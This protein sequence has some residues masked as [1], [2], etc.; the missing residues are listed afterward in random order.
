MQIFIRNC[1]GELLPCEVSSTETVEM[2]KQRI[3]QLQGTEVSEIR[4]AS[5]GQDLFDEQLLGDCTVENGILE[6]LLRLRGAGKKRKK[7]NYTKPKKIKHKKKKVKLATL[8]Y[9]KVDGQNKVV[10]LRRQCEHPMCGPGIFMANHFD[11]Q[12]CG[13]CFLTYKVDPNAPKTAAK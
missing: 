9:Y 10:R 4:L 5:M 7:K 3:S 12:Y 1:G 11:R 8:K 2:L 6:T 13:K